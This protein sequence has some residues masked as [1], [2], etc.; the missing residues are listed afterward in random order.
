MNK[1]P[2]F[3]DVFGLPLP[4][5]ALY[6]WIR[7]EYGEDAEAEARAVWG[8]ANRQYARALRLDRYRRDLLLPSYRE[9]RNA[10]RRAFRQQA[11]DDP[12]AYLRGEIRADEGGKW[13]DD[14]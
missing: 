8:R 3:V 5:D 10:D 6:A 1:P 2:S 14:D 9:P 11:L 7:Q 12:A 13:S 4:L